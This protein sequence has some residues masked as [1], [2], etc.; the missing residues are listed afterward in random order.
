M[1]FKRLP[2]NLDDPILTVFFDRLQCI[3]A[4][5]D[6]Q[7]AEVAKHYGFHCTGCEDNCCRTRFNHHTYLE[8]LYIHAGLNQL[9]LQRQREMQSSAVVIC[10]E[11]AKADEKALPVR[12][13]CPLNSDGLCVLYT[14]RPM[15]CRLH[16]ISHELR[17]PGQNAIRGPGCGMFDLRCS[18]KSYRKF[19]RTPFYFEM[20][21]LEN[22]LKQAV[23]LSGR[24]K[25]T[26]AEMI[27]ARRQMTEV[28]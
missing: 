11:N 7:Y 20:A 2:V 27:I 13:M 19:D 28:R 8:Y 5:M 16:G 21:K 23:G 26:I 12:L 14:Y 10:R 18:D 6:R 4:A 24:I 3:F 9:S 22:E 1:V 25:M 17:K 15:I